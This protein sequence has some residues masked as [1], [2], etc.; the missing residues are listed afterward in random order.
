VKKNFSSS[1]IIWATTALIITGILIIAIISRN[2]IVRNTAEAFN[3]QQ[4]FLVRESALGL[5]E[6]LKNLEIS[7]KTAASLIPAATREKV[8]KSFFNNQNEFLQSVHIVKNNGKTVLSFP[9][10]SSELFNKVPDLRE[11]I[12]KSNKDMFMTDICANVCNVRAKGGSTLSLIMGVSIKGGTEWIC[13]VPDFNA[14]NKRF[15]SPV[16]SGRTGYAWMIN[17]TGVLLAHPN[18]EMEGRRAIDILKELWPDQA[19]FNLEALINKNMLKMEEGSGEY[20]GWHVG[21]KNQTKKLIAYCPVN[22]KWLHWSIGVSAPYSEVMSPLMKSLT[23]PAI[24]L[25]CFIVIILACATMLIIQENRKRSVNQEL[26]W[27]NEAFDNITDGIS[28]IDKNYRVLKVNRAV[29]DWQKNTAQYFKGKP[30]YKVFQQE[31]GLCAGCPAKEVFKTGKPASRQR[32]STTVGGKKYYFHLSAFPLKDNTGK[33]VRVAECVRDV[34]NEMEL[35][36]E[37]I[38]SEQKSMI[39]K[40]SAQVAHEI[41]NPLGTLTLNIDLLEDEISSYSEIDTAEAKKR[42]SIVKS[43]TENLHKVLKE[44]LEC[45][46]FPTIKPEKHYI[47]AILREM[48][49]AMEEDFRQKQVQ[50]KTSLEYNLPPAN[51]DQDQ[52]KRAFL[53]IILNA[54][55]EMKSGGIIEISTCT[56]DKWI[57]ITFTDTGA[58]ISNENKDKIF[59][60]FYTT[61]SSGTGLGLSITKHIITEHQGEIL[62]Q[63]VPEKGASFI[64][65]LPVMEEE[66]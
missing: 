4:L 6:H 57:E 31:E 43:E 32:V 39:V 22:Y 26:N 34:T 49:T 46:R 9:P 16:R 51:V 12:L 18:K 41:R 1:V 14:I 53:N 20:T 38:N 28:I 60:P 30:C 2:V 15:I 44:Y 23:G 17:S 27:S 66:V 63:N 64:V 24:F 47:N 50:S 13:A 37:L 35:R 29:C 7:L 59:T 52:L 48:F 8:L 45:T 40:M 36:S 25:F 21:E 19:S 65:R 33:T 5:E 42:V 56:V 62:C 55:D 54:L 11:A 58:G 10:K 3:R 61:K